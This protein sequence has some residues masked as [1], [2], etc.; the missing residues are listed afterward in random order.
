MTE[1]APGPVIS[2]TGGGTGARIAAL[3][4]GIALTGVVAVAVV[5]RPPPPAPVPVPPSPVAVRSPTPTAAEAPLASPDHPAPAE[6]STASPRPR[7]V[8]SYVIAGLIGGTSFRTQLVESAPGSGEFWARYALPDP[9]LRDGTLAFEITPSPTSARSRG[10]TLGVFL[11]DLE[12]LAANHRSGLE[13][14]RAV[15]N[16]RPALAGAPLP[17]RNGFELSVSVALAFDYVATVEF[18][19]HVVRARAS[20]Q[21]N[22]GVI[23]CLPLETCDAQN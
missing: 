8:G 19:L 12:S 13:G 14:Y 20:L 23:G 6:P 3:A 10:D 7:A 22:D 11:L 15:V 5:G 16:G 2:G 4:T 18:G 1:P 17:V 21:G 9:V